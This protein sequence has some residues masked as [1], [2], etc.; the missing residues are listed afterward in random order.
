MKKTLII[1]GSIIVILFAIVVF[2]GWRSSGISDAN[3]KVIKGGD[4][5]ISYLKNTDIN[6]TSTTTWPSSYNTVYNLSLP[7]IN[8]NSLVGDADAKA[9][10]LTPEFSEYLKSNTSDLNRIIKVSPFD[11]NEYA[12]HS[13]VGSGPLDFDGEGIKICGKYQITLI[14]NGKIRTI[15]V[16]NDS[17]AMLTGWDPSHF[18]IYEGLSDRNGL[19]PTDLDVVL[20]A[21]EAQYLKDD[22]ESN[23]KLYVVDLLGK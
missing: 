23:S 10:I 6:W 13:C 1:I 22:F 16:V 11:K 4:T 9:K 17:R 2:I 20:F 3:T 5:I 14:D 12:I 19:P 21:R 15:L 7:N 8:D 18:Y